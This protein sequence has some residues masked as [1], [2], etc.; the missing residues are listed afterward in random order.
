VLASQECGTLL[1]FSDLHNEHR[2]VV[3]YICCVCP[4][5]NQPVAPNNLCSTLRSTLNEGLAMQQWS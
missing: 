5:A 2:F 4:H 1:M 3:S